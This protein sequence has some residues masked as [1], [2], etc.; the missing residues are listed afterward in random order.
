MCF[1]PVCR[2]PG[3]DCKKRRFRGLPEE[4]ETIPRKDWS[5]AVVPEGSLEFSWLRGF[6]CPREAT[7]NPTLSVKSQT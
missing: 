5:A 4:P 2:M 3:F 7:N 6:E 1:H